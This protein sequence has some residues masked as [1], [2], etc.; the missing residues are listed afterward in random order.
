MPEPST[1]GREDLIED[2]P[3][4]FPRPMVVERIDKAKLARQTQETS[5]TNATLSRY[6]RRPLCLPVTHCHSLLAK[7]MF[8]RSKEK[9]AV[10]TANS[11]D[12]VTRIF[13]TPQQSTTN[14]DALVKR[15]LMQNQELHALCGIS[16]IQEG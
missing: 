1:K 13:L 11:Q 9:R 16:V 7:P 10:P 14:C 4:R 5:S 12:R 15:R 2:D 8:N 3:V 6:G